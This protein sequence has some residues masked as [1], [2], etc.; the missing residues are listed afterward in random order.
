MFGALSAGLLV[1][2]LCSIRSAP[3]SIAATAAS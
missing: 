1:A 3:G 2:G